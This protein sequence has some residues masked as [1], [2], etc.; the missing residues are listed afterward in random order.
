MSRESI[1]RG[2]LYPGQGWGQLL[3]NSLRD[4]AYAFVL[5]AELWTD[6][7]KQHRIR[8]DAQHVNLAATIRGNGTFD[9]DTATAWLDAGLIQLR[10]YRE[11][12]RRAPIAR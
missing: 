1:M 4:L 11:E 9:D 12:R 8:R 5:E 3:G 2:R 7:E 6:V 10:R